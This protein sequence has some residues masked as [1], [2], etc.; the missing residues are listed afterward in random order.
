MSIRQVM[1]DSLLWLGV[2]LVLISCLG[3][4]VIPGV[5]ERLHFSS[6]AVLGALLIAAAV[7]VQKSFSLVGDKALLVAVFFLV[8]SPLVTHVTGRAARIA[9]LGDWRVNEIVVEDP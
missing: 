9:Q 4:L 1:V 8:A 2:T 5:Y 3:V 6:P 7:A